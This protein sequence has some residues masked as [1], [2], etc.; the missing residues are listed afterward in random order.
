MSVIVAEVFDP[1]SETFFVL[2]IIIIIE[3]DLS[4]Y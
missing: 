3:A 4:A 2:S 1:R